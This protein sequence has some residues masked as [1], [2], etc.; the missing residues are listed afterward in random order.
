ML[1]EP[2]GHHI[3]G[4]NE[5][6]T[7]EPLKR[8]RTYRTVIQIMG[9][10]AALGVFAA[11]IGSLGTQLGGGAGSAPTSV[12]SPRTVQP[13]L[14]ITVQRAEYAYGYFKVVGIVKN[15][16]S[17]PAFSPTVNLRV[18]RGDTVLAEDSA[19]PVGTLLRQLPVGGEAAFE[20][21]SRVP[22]DPGSEWI[23]YEVAMSKYGYDVRYPK[24]PRTSLEP[25]LPRP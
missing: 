22:G 10:V 17:A 4:E 19:W 13:R 25:S 16:G 6:K 7:P 21:S 1:T 11:L 8:R 18:T 3:V 24:A 15:V 14:L 23:S 12:A 5:S 9:I 20:V 2:R